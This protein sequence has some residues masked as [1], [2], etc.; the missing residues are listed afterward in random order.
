MQRTKPQNTI[1]TTPTPE[2]LTQATNI[3]IKALLNEGS[4]EEFSAQILL[5]D[6]KQNHMAQ[7]MAQAIRGLLFCADLCENSITSNLI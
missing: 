3:I 5:W 4:E 2:V 6:T 1:R 7:S